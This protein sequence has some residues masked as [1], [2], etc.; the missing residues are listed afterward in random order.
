MKPIEMARKLAELNEVADAQQA[1][2]LALHDAE[3]KDPEVELEAASYIFFSKGNYKAAYTA[4]ISLFNRGYAQ[5]ELLELMTQAFYLP[6][7]ADQKKRY[8]TNCKILSKYPYFF[9]ADFPAFEELSIQFF[10]FDKKGCLPY[11][12]EGPRFGDYVNFND[13]I[14]DRYFFKDLDNPILAADVYSQY[15]LEYLYDSVRKSEWVARDNHIYLHYTNK[16][17]FFAHLQCLDFKKLLRDEKFV[18]LLE[19]EISQYPIDFKAR[20]GIDYSQYPVKPIGIREVNRMIWHTQLS[21]HNGGDFFNEILHGHPN[22]LAI[23][24]LMFENISE[25]VDT[26]MKALRDGRISKGRGYQKLQLLKH[27]TPKD[28]LIYLFLYSEESGPLPDPNVRIAP[29]LLFQPHFSNLMYDATVVDTNKGWTTIHSK[30]Y[31]EI[32]NSP[33]FQGFKYIKTFTPMRRITTSYAASTRF[34]IEQPH[35]DEEDR[36]EKKDAAIPDMVNL[37]I[38]NRSFMIDQWDRLYRD[39][40][41]VRFE[42]AKLNPKATF[43]ALAEFLDIPYTHSMTYCS[44]HKGLDPESLKGNVRG[45]DTAAVYRTYDEYA[46]VEEREFLE[47]FFRDA[48]EAY[49]YDFMYYK[50]EPVDEEWIRDKVTHFT[51]VNE[52]TAKRWESALRNGVSVE[53]ILSNG[54]REKVNPFDLDLTEN[55]QKIVDKFSEDRQALAEHLLKNAHFI[56]NWGQ[57]LQMMPLLKLDPALLEQPLYH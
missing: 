27:P 20:F 18:F 48:Y 29:I 1:Y 38:L 28:C 6:N 47:F 52:L 57:P 49:G 5:G 8:E 3:G 16:A 9:G 44:S 35:K 42:D 31:D 24:S 26:M 11:H 12:P 32:K 15:Q 23:E 4:F 34:L 40:V 19:D 54:Q 17:T 13:T 46:S 51:Y 22:L 25:T 30:E 55:A 50:G 7:V 53:K 45:F 14:I 37:R 56:N 43:T 2:F 10:P 41:L 36:D 33:L 21:A 39:S